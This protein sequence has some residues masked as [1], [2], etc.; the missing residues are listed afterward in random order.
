MAESA[1]VKNPLILFVD[2]DEWYH[3]RWATGAL[4]SRW[5]SVDD[6]LRDTYH[7]DKPVGEILEPTRWM[8][9]CFG[10]HDTKVTFAI[11]GEVAQWYPELVQ[12]IAQEGHS[13]A[14]HGMHHQD[15]T[16]LSRQQF[17]EQLAQAR[18]ILEQISGKRVVGFRAP[19]LVVAEWLPEVLVEQGFAYDSS[20][21]PAR[22][23]GKFRE[24]SHAPRRPYQV[25]L[26]SLFR[27][28]NSAL[29][30]IPMS[31]FPIIRMPG[32]QSIMTRIAGWPW[33][34]ITLDTAL[35][36]GPACYYMHPY[37]FNPTQGLRD[38]R[39]NERVFLMRTGSYMKGNLK[40]LLRKYGGIIVTAE[41]YVSRHFPRRSTTSADVTGTG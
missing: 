38:M 41:E 36:S 6:C 1:D 35:R 4:S 7:S 30:E 18:Q 14:C 12:Q 17:S 23:P 15:I 26:N 9:N 16:L 29:V 21:C 3:C 33:T 25:S 11:L 8:L 24:H 40:K 2:L 28:G 37:E 20:V 27:R 32:G 10:E 31:V 19:N 39:F 13:I 22:N 5:A 34:S